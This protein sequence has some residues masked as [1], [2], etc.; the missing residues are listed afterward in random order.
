MGTPEDEMK[1]CDG[2]ADSDV[3]SV[4]VPHSFRD[5]L[6]VDRRTRDRKVAGLNPG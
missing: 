6:L 2:D 5:S 4:K 3:I 1:M